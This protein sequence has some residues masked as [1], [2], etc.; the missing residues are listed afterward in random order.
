MK[1]AKGSNYAELHVS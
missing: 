1:K